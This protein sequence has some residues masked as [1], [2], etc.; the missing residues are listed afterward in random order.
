MFFETILTRNAAH[1]YRATGWWTDRLLNDALTVAVARYPGRIALVDGRG[2]MTYAT[3][4][5]Q[6]D[7]CAL[8]L[9]ALGIRHGD[10]VTAQL[11]N[12]NEFVVMTLALERIGAVINPVAPIFRHRELRVMLRLAGSVAAVIPARFRN[13]DYRA[14]YADLKADAPALKQLVV[15]DGATE[16]HDEGS[17]SWP[18]LLAKGA[19]QS[20]SRKVLDWCRP[21]PDDVAQLIFTSG[22]SG[23][24]KGVLHT[25]NTLGAQIEAMIQCHQLTAGDVFHMASTVGHQ[26]GFLLGVRLPLHLG[27]RAVYQE[28]WDPVEFIRLT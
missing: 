15:I 19:A 10:V 6:V 24:P 1:E 28:V 2:R 18:Q 8:G 9:L 23:E 5:A 25:A 11:P 13:W 16:G 7:Q 20:V 26:T 14:M 22:T 27:A 17:L 21:S 12:W 4:Q 3:L